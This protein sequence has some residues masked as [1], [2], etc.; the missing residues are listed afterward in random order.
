MATG[1]GKKKQDFLKYGWGQGVIVWPW[2]KLIWRR[3]EIVRC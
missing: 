1:S 3:G 2:K